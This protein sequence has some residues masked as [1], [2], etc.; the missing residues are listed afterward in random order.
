ML[1]RLVDMTVSARERFRIDLP[2][3]S[4]GNSSAWKLI[5]NRTLPA[6]VNQLRLGEALLL[7]QETV[8]LDPIDG[9]YRDAILLDAEIIEVKDKPLSEGGH[10]SMRRAILALGSQDVCRGALKP[11]DENARIL[12]RSSDHLVVD[13]TDS[14][15]RYKVGDCMRFIPSYEAMLAA[16]TSPF[17]EK[18]PVR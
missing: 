15:D 16:M 12:L 2:V 7:G 17:V 1:D 5:E 18:V 4:G 9:A 10:G 14:R 8:D 13:V 3:I 6:G 11:I